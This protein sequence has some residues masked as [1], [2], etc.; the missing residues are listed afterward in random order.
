MALG[1]IL[2]EKYGISASVLEQTDSTNNLAKAAATAGAAEWSCFIA[3]RQTGGRGRTGKQFYSPE[4]GLYLS[5][6]LRPRFSCEANLLIT[7]AAAAATKSAL[8]SVFGKNAQI[9]WVNDI[10]LDGKKVCGI[11]A[12]TALMGNSP[13]YTVLGIGINLSGNQNDIPD[14]LKSIMGFIEKTPVSDEQKAA[15]TAKIIEE[16]KKY[17]VNLESKPHL[18]FYKENMICDRPITVVREDGGFNAKILGLDD[19]FHLIIEGD[20]GEQKLSFGEVS[21][22]L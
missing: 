2:F 6:I 19:D 8:L 4:G 9:K 10:I 7:T 12:E 3:N 18:N 1:E 11:L 20:S 15:L 16:F 22:R 14:E 17:Y 21:I 13:A 5:I